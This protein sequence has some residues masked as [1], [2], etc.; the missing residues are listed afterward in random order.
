MLTP[1]A[2]KHLAETIR[3]TAQDPSKG[4]RARLLAAIHDEADRRYRLSVPLADAR[5]DEAH[6]RRRE[7]LDAWTDERARATRPKNKAALEAAKA[8]LL[9]QAEKEAAATLLTRLVLLRHLEALGLSRPQVLT[10]GWGSKGYR[11]FREFAPT[12]CTNGTTDATEGY[13]TLLQILFDELAGDLPF[14]FGDVGLTRLFPRA[15]ASSHRPHCV[16]PFPLCRSI[17]L[18]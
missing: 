11:E 4:V 1:E 17:V 18:R 10:G 13:A 12:L 15:G 3:G 6:R 14:L 2:K 8:R 7:R 16:R 9:T 5:L